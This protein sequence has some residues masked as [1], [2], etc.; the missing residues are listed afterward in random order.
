MAIISWGVISMPV[1]YGAFQDSGEEASST[2]SHKAPDKCPL[3]LKDSQHSIILERSVFMPNHM[4]GKSTLSFE[5]G[6]FTVHFEEKTSLISPR[7]IF[8]MPSK[9]EGSQLKAFLSQ[10]DSLVFKDNGEEEYEIEAIMAARGGGFER[11]FEQFIA[12][13]SAN[14]GKALGG[15][16]TPFAI[17]YIKKQLDDQ[18]VRIKKQEGRI[19]KLESRWCSI[20]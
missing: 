14:P 2:I 19:K 20:M 16:S 3:I 13:I 7:N 4:A 10:G 9:I 8:G 18:E 6:Q 11:G 1:A 12:F 5:E 17:Y 15:G